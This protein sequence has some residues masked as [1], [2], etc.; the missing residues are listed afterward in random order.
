MK[1][2]N[3]KKL[4][5]ISYYTAQLLNCVLMCGKIVYFVTY[6]TYIHNMQNVAATELAKTKFRGG[7]NDMISRENFPILSKILLAISLKKL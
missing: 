5:I 2:K 4:E 3:N 6:S 7:G 1:F